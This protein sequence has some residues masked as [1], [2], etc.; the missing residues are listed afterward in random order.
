MRK[1]AHWVRPAPPM[2]RFIR[3]AGSAL[4]VVVVVVVVVVAVVVSVDQ[5]L[6]HNIYHNSARPFFK[7]EFSLYLFIIRPL[8]IH[9]NTTSTSTSS[10][11]ELRRKQ[12]RR[13]QAHI[14]E[15]DI[16]SGHYKY[17]ALMAFTQDSPSG[18]PKAKRKYEYIYEIYLA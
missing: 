3:C 8:V 17:A 16:W 6:E 4:V 10:F 1:P 15:L 2:I 5:H 9:I 18:R 7:F 14:R 12:I 11:A 13:M